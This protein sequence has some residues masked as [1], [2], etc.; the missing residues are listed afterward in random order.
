MDLYENA[1]GEEAAS[2]AEPEYRDFSWEWWPEYVEVRG[3]VE[4]IEGRKG[5]EQGVDAVG[6]S[7]VKP[8]T[9]PQVA[10]NVSDGE[11]YTTS[12]GVREHRE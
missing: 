7:T 3:W 1:L 6:F 5:S 8:S 4:R 12:I 2:T 10:E 11:R 9:V